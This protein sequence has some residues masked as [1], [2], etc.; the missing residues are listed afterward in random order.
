M[1]LTYQNFFF[2]AAQVG[3]LNIRRITI[4]LE[5]SQRPQ[6]FILDSTIA[7]LLKRKL[8]KTYCAFGA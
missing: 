7:K 5:E 2:A 3:H 4:Q 1:N 6:W 8:K